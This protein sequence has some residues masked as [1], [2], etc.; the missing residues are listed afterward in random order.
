MPCEPHR[1]LDQT[2]KGETVLET[3]SVRSPDKEELQ[4]EV[5][6]LV[7]RLVDGL[8]QDIPEGTSLVVYYQNGVVY[9]ACIER[10][11]DSLRHPGRPEGG[12]SSH[13]RSVQWSPQIGLGT[14]SLVA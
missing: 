12:A 4:L 2:W 7:A 6:P 10:E 9:Q 11:A 3:T 13:G 14:F 8:E 5:D 1:V